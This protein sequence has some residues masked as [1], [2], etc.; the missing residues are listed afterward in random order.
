MNRWEEAAFRGPV[1]DGNPF[2][3]ERKGRKTG[4]EEDRDGIFS[5]NKIPPS[6]TQKFLLKNMKY[7]ETI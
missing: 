1:P 2:A 4:K 3:K 6:E 5:K 7:F